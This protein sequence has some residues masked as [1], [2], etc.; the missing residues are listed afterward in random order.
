MS[1]PVT[2]PAD[3]AV[4]A[5]SAMPPVSPVPPELLGIAPNPGAVSPSAPLAVPP[6]TLAVIELIARALAPDADDQTR[7]A[8]RELWARFAQMIAMAPGVLA[9]PGAPN[10]PAGPF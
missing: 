8:A 9:T 5:P 2:L 4:E 6:E 7:A 3:S 1:E 10:V